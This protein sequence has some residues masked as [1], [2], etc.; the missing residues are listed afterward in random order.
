MKYEY[1]VKSILSE[2][3]VKVED[4]TTHGALWKGAKELCGHHNIEWVE[5]VSKRPI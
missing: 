2:K 4:W 1:I 5:I 3:T